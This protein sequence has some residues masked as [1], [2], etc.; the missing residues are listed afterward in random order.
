MDVSVI[1]VNTN[2]KALILNC[3]RSIYEKSQDIGFEIFVVDNASSDGSVE[4]IKEQNPKVN[5]IENKENLGFSAA[6]NQPTY[7]CKGRNIL[8]LNPDTL[9][10]DNAL[11]NMSDF[12]DHNPKVGAVGCKLLNI[13]GSLQPSCRNFLTNRN[14]LLQ[15][16]LPW[17]KLF[18]NYAGKLILE[19]WDHDHIREVDWI[20]GACLMVKKHVIDE[21]GLKDENFFMFHEETDWCYRSKLKGWKTVF[22]PTS[23]IIHFGGHTTKAIWGRKLVLKYYEGKHLFIKKHYGNRRLFI[24]RFLMSN[25][26]I[27]RLARFTFRTTFNQLPNE[28]KKETFDFF[29]EALTMQMG[30]DSI[31]KTKSQRG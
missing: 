17:R 7:L 30:L 23:S 9:V 1:I 14:L 28:E 24:H 20:I 19:Y 27:L 8:F 16:I 31:S 4:A 18:P 2:E 25:L 5:V 12:L 21:V 15:H 13:D 6:C 11:K 10:L 22:L 29:K 3:L 26:L